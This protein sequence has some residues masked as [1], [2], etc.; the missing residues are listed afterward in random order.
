MRSSGRRWGYLAPCKVIGSIGHSFIPPLSKGRS[1]RL[2]FYDSVDGVVSALV[3]C[4]LINKFIPRAD[5]WSR[6]G[7]VG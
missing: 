6:M 1:L 4:K 7:A 5:L 3:T 2:G